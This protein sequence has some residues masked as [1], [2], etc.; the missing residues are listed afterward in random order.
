M[1]P[2]V[3]SA[4]ADIHANTVE[5]PVYW[6]QLEPRAGQFDFSLVNILVAQ[7]REHRVRLILLW[8]G[9]WKNGSQHYMPAWMKREPQRYFHL[10]N[11]AGEEMDSPSLFATASLEADKRAFTALM[12][13]LRETDLQHTVILI[14]V[15]NEPRTWG[16]VRDY[17][18]AAQKAFEAPVPASLLAGLHKEASGA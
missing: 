4:I 12:R 15:E 8:F 11:Q 18:P 6:E 9:T 10:V 5:M 2:K 14:Q 1:L 3:W 16:S 13:H 17:S 7:A